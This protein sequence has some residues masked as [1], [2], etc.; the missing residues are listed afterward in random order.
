M[1]LSVHDEHHGLLGLKEEKTVI[2]NQCSILSSIY[3][4]SMEKCFNSSM[5]LVIVCD[6]IIV[7]V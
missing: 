7:I 6:Y 1:S 4:K 2:L 5:A 3:M